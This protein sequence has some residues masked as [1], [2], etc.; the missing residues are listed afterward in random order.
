MAITT[1]NI[2][3]EQA[4]RILGRRTDDSDIDDREICLLVKQSMAYFVRQ[5]YFT[6]KNDDIAEIP[7]ILVKTF[8]NVDVEEDKDMGDFFSKLPSSVMDLPHGMG[9]K[10]VAP[11]GKA[12]GAYIPVANTFGSM[13]CDLESSCLE[14]RIGFYQDGKKIRYE[15][16]SAD[17][18]PGKV[19]IR[20]VAPIDTI[21]DDDEID[22]PSDM[23]IEILDNVLERYGIYRQQDE[24]NDQIDQV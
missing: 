12:K 10:L 11:Q 6:S 4:K 21:S 19:M 22:V 14:G 16:M 7:D 17:K 20:L 8:T 18:S 1:C 3:A 15:N 24:S 13:Y 9:I 23:Q 5:R 2:L